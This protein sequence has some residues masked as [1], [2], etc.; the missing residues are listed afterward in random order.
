MSEQGRPP[1]GPEEMDRIF[2]KAVRGGIA[3]SAMRA[4]SVR[5]QPDGGICYIVPGPIGLMPAPGREGLE[6]VNK[7]RTD[8]L[9]GV[10]EVNG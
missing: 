8:R 6:P 1:I 10:E 4:S 7:G 3:G 5:V 9:T 2:R